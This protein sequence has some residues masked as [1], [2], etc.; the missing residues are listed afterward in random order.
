M[1]YKV[2]L[3]T[4]VHRAIAETVRWYSDNYSADFAARW[5]D[6]L[7]EQLKDLSQEPERHP[8]ARENDRDDFE[9]RELHFGAGKRT[10][11]RIV[12]HVAGSA[13]KVL[14]IRHVAQRD[15]EADELT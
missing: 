9:L 4:P 12:F 15:F 1:K 13:V 2:H 8:L 14:G 5:Y 7:I 11:H 10:T 6:G 3:T